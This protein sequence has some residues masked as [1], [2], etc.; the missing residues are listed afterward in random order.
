MRKAW[1][2]LQGEGEESIQE[3]TGHESGHKFSN[4]SVPQ[5]KKKHSLVPQMSEVKVKV[6][7]KVLYP[8]KKRSTVLYPRGRRSTVLHPR[9]KIEKDVCTNRQGSDLLTYTKELCTH[10]T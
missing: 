7:H 2:L 3:R 1:K 10:K 9:M 5:R 8:R 6:K 4:L